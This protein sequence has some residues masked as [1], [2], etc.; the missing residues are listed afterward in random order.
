MFLMR[1]TRAT[2]RPLSTN[3]REVV[4]RALLACRVAPE[5]VCLRAVEVARIVPRRPRAAE[6]RGPR[7]LVAH[8]ALASRADGIA[9]GTRV[10]IRRALFDDE[11]RLPLDLLAHEVAHVAQILRDGA[12]A[13]YLRYGVAY[14][15]GRA[16][17]L[18]DR[19]AYLA[20]PYEEEARRVGAATDPSAGPVRRIR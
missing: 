3:E 11:G 19:R 13:F 17:G 10:F 5:P 8:V 18:D 2:H 16:R 15:A 14:A 7:S 1:E 4:A 12:L 20:I 6:V 9:L